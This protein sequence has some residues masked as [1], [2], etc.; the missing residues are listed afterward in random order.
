MYVHA[1]ETGSI[2][3]EEQ[4][5]FKSSLLMGSGGGQTSGGISGSSA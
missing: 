3:G 1:G 5:E 4:Q 2:F